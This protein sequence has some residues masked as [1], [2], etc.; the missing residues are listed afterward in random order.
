MSGDPNGAPF[1]TA[2]KKR[3]YRTGEAE[4][5]HPSSERLPVYGP[6]PTNKESKKDV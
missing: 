3:E 6:A 2:R 5:G 1:Q 4:V